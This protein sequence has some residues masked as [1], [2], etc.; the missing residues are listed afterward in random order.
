MVGGRLPV[1]K[2]LQ[3]RDALKSAVVHTLEY[4]L[5]LAEVPVAVPEIVPGVLRIAVGTVHVTGQPQSPGHAG[6][7]SAAPR[8]LHFES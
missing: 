7:V 2:Y 6:M 4:E 8:P 3:A 1:I 5:L